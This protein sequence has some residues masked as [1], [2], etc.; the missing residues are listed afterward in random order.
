MVQLIQIFIKD[1]F[2]CICHSMI[3]IESVFK[4]GKNYYPRVFSE[5][6]KYLI[7]DFQLGVL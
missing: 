3:L 4:T 5:E 7:N 1:V 6:C 2:R